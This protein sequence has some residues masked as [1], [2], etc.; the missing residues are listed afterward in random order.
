MAD[1]RSQ[2]EAPLLDLKA[3]AAPIREE[4]PTAIDRVGDR[5]QFI[6]GP[7][8]DALEDDVATYCG[9]AQAAGASSGTHA[10]L[11]S[12]MAL[13]VGRGDEVVTT[14]YSFSPTPGSIARLGA[15]PNPRGHRRR[16]P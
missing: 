12:L 15:A 4:I 1:H 5:A 13:G 6:I 2:V 3:D 7:E 11:L 16:V 10:I 14:P 9:S 8:V